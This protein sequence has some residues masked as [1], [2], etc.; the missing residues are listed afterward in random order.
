MHTNIIC[1]K[2]GRTSI[3]HKA[4]YPKTDTSPKQSGTP[5][6]ACPVL[7][8]NMTILTG[9]NTC[10][11]TTARGKNPPCHDYIKRKLT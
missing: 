3:I 10:N 8:H 11:I 4:T 9:I 1:K 6:Y 5:I 2:E 7:H